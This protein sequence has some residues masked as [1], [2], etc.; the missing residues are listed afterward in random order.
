LIFWKKILM[1]VSVV[2]MVLLGIPFIFGPLRQSSL[3]LRLLAG[4]VIGF[5]FYLSSEIFGPLSLVY[6]FPPF[7]AAAAPLVLFAGAG[8]A[9]LR[10]VR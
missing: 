5:I 2:I 10:K 1:P 9:I 4:I 3:G 6:A 8:Y 7:L